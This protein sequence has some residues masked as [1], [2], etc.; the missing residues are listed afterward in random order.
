MD[1]NRIPPAPLFRDPIYDGAADPVVTFNPIDKKWYMMYTQRRANV[2]CSGISYCYGSKIGVVVSED[3]GLSWCYRGALNLEFEWGDNTFWA[4][5]IIFDG[6]IF[7]M[8]VT[9]IRGIW[10]DWKGQS[11]IVHYTSKD[12]LNW[13]KQSFL[14]LDTPTSIDSCIYKLPN[15]NYRM[16]YRNNSAGDKFT[17]AADSEDL[18]NWN[19]VGHVTE[20]F[21]YHE[22]QN[23]FKLGGY[24]WLIADAGLGMFVWRSNDLETWTPQKE[25]IMLNPGTKRI[26]DGT[27]GGHG[28]VVICGENG[29]IFYFIHPERT[30]EFW[31]TYDETGHI[32]IPYKLRRSSIQV[33]KLEVIEGKLYCDRDAEFELNLC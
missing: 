29:Y 27:R 7:H 1:K 3:K 18:F 30:G 20:G 25:K 9:Y 13:E 22:G 2:P 17:W 15:G 19:V 21:P 5:E 11:Y 12:I 32:D 28:D 14:N 23:V 33:A 26:E 8:Y 6:N 4:P 31:N 10:R 24:Y 16:W